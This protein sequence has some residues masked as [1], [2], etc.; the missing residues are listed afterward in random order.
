M[1]GRLRGRDNSFC[2][3]MIDVDPVRPGFHGSIRGRTVETVVGASE[4][5]WPEQAAQTA[6]THRCIHRCNLSMHNPSFHTVLET[7]THPTS[8]PRRLGLP[9]PVLVRAALV[10]V[11]VPWS[12]ESPK[13]GR[14]D[15][16]VQRHGKPTQG[17]KEPEIDRFIAQDDVDFVDSEVDVLP[18]PSIPFHTSWNLC[19]R[20]P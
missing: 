15:T 7:Q 6:P 20:G 3:N 11:R 9:Q 8:R 2:E 4:V 19:R 14:T 1:Q 5:A 18:V 13:S 17:R 12:V 16:A 10:L